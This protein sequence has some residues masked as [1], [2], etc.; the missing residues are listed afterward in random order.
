MH[1]ES[2]RIQ[3]AYVCNHPTL[4]LML[5]KCKRTPIHCS[6]CLYVCLRDKLTRKSNIVA[7]VSMCCCVDSLLIVN[8]KRSIVIP[9]FGIIN[10]MSSNAG[11]LPIILVGVVYKV[12]LSKLYFESNEGEREK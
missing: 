1:S 7:I 8:D 10:Q 3:D 2:L 6:H 9:H 12:I 5:V 4:F 11:A